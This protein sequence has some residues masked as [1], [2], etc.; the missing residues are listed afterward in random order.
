MSLSR[1][2]FL[3]TLSLAAVAGL[4]PGAARAN[5]ATPYQ[6]PFAGNVRLLH[7]TDTH[8]Q[9]MP[10]YYREPSV[11]IGVGNAAGQPGCDSPA[12]GTQRPATASRS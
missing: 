5:T 2:E 3:H 11:N 4:L 9:L 6:L 12:T 7:M 10:V 8:A 1:R